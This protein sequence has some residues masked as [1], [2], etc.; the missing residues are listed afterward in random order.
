MPLQIFKN[1]SLH[2]TSRSNETARVDSNLTTKKPWF[3][4]FSNCAC[5]KNALHQVIPVE[6][7]SEPRI[8]ALDLDRSIPTERDYESDVSSIS[9]GYD[10]IAYGDLEPVIH[11]DLLSDTVDTHSKFEA[12]DYEREFSFEIKESHASM[13][14]IRPFSILKSTYKKESTISLENLKKAIQNER[15]LNIGFLHPHSEASSIGSIKYDI[16]IDKHSFDSPT[17]YHL[18]SKEDIF[19]GL[20]PRSKTA[21]NALENYYLAYGYDSPDNHHILKEELANIQNDIYQVNKKYDSNISTSQALIAKTYS[22]PN[23]WYG[24]FNSDLRS[25]IPLSHSVEI[26][27][28]FNSFIESLA[29][30]QS[31]SEPLIVFRGSSINHWSI[32]ELEDA[33]HSGNSIKTMSF[34]SAT[35]NLSIADKFGKCRLNDDRVPILIT[36]KDEGSLKNGKR[37]GAAASIKFISYFPDEEEVIFKSGQEFRVTGFQAVVDLDFK[38]AVSNLLNTYPAFE[39]DTDIH[40]KNGILYYQVIFKPIHSHDTSPAV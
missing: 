30:S 27:F 40:D 10:V 31:I 20:S 18:T 35:S 29:Q 23:F 14:G 28:H 9:S 33:Y 25:S 12:H 24:K 36:I 32:E 2:S 5:S 37:Y 11:E 13:L 16:P 26:A 19:T 17:I 39:K 6:V 4:F 7:M 21:F 8:L 15:I 3:K 34:F 22:S 38:N 1:F